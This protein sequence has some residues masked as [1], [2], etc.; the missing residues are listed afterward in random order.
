MKIGLD[1]NGYLYVERNGSIQ[2]KICPYH[3]LGRGCGLWCPHFDREV[4]L[5][6]RDDLGLLHRECPP[7]YIGLCH[8]TVIVERLESEE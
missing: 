3:A 6:E 2:E 1:A 5:K 7:N 8:G 4:S